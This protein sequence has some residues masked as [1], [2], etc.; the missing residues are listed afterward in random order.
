V[1]IL[2]D[3]HVLLWF[4]AAD[5]RLGRRARA[6]VSAPEHAALISLVSLW[7]IA[8]KA[9]LGK[10][11]ADFEAVLDIV[12]ATDFVMLDLKSSHLRALTALPVLPD[13]RDPFDH[14]LIA[15]AMAEDAA[16]MTD[17]PRAGHY[18]VRIEPC[19]S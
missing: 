10:L 16:F 2:L 7:E 13:H 18:P 6:M 3:T 11:E 4:I 14:L 12:T 17:D 9:R 8:L 15:Q 1:R 5:P 19:R